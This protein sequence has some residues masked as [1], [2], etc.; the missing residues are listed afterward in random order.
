MNIHD[1]VTIVILAA[2]LGT[3]MKSRHAKV[4]HPAGGRTL[5]G[6]SVKTALT[7][8][9]PERVFVVV[10]HQAERVR[11]NVAATGVRFI[12]Q[13]EQKGTGHAILCGRDALEQYGGRLLVFYGDCPLILPT[14][15]D[16]FL[17]S[18]ATLITTLLDDPT[19]Y[20][21][22]VRD[23][24]GAV[25][26]IVEQKAATPEQLAIREI[27][28]GIYCFQAETFWRLAGRMTTDNP[29]GE[30]YLTDMIAIL[31]GDGFPVNA[32]VVD[33]SAELLGI[34][35]RVELAAA[36]HVLRAR[37]VR[38]LMLDGV[39]IEKPETVT[40][41]DPVRVG[42]DSTIGP[43]AQ[44]RGNTVVGENCRIGACS[45][46]EDSEL[47]ADVEIGAFT[48]VGTSTLERGA[49]AGPFARLRMGNRLGEGVHIG[50]FVELK[51]A[52]LG[53]GTK[54]GHL[55]YLGDAVVGEGTNIGAGTIT[56]NYD[57]VAK[58][59]TTIGSHAFVGSNA[60]LVAPVEIADGAYIAAGSAITQNVPGEALAV[61]RSRQVNKEGYARKLKGKKP[62]S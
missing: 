51:K 30:Y 40:V 23:R 1:D 22:V 20:G 36:D 48:T 10:G 25:Q 8:A 18:G 49:T 44:L 6:H 15:L 24:G 38:Q 29:A 58:H 32:R 37:K 7:L 50:N 59:R 52:T 27:N 14:T 41:D 60:T 42:M 47:G 39:T 9:R 54:A 43:F 61:G 19:G 31:N 17:E 55:A 26:A 28:A 33:D 13:T 21:R 35:N 3:R 53:A 2:G 46:I 62:A 4:L 16:A 34:N 56:C 5:I 11:E 57:G 45:I 12:H